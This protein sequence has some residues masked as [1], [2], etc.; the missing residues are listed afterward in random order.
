MILGAIWATVKW[1]FGVAVDFVSWSIASFGKITGSLLGFLGIATPGAF[2]LWI[3]V[4]T[5]KSLLFHSGKKY[6]YNK[7]G[8][9]KPKTVRKRDLDEY[10][11]RA[12]AMNYGFL[13]GGDDKG[14]YGVPNDEEIYAHNVWAGWTWHGAA[15]C[16]TGIYTYKGLFSGKNDYMSYDDLRNSGY[17]MSYLKIHFDGF[18]E[19]FYN[20]LI[21]LRDA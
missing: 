13:D 11:I 19:V 17:D 3:V 20:L 9:D 8:L 10:E 21:E 5:I 1:L 7:L 6:V 16:T 2:I 12:I 14:N 4:S 15:L 18:P